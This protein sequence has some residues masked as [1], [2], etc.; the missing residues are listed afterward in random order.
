[1]K[2]PSAAEMFRPESRGVRCAAGVR[3]IS[4]GAAARARTAGALLRVIARRNA[5]RSRLLATPVLMLDANGAVRMDALLRMAP[6]SAIRAGSASR[7][8]RADYRG[9]WWVS[10]RLSFTSDMARRDMRT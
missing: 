9:I 4:G 3:L 10:D 2:A 5:T 7:L 8:W 6:G 1:M